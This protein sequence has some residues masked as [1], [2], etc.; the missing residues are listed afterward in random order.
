MAPNSSPATLTR[1][2]IELILSK[3]VVHYQDIMEY[4]G[5][6]R[7]TITKYLN[8]VEAI[9]NQQGVEL[10]RKR[11]QGIHFRGNTNAL[12]AKFPALKDGSQSEE[13][14]RISIM[15][16]LTQQSSPILLDDIADHFF[17]S[18]STLE[19][20]LNILKSS[21]GLKLTATTEG[22]Q[23]KSSEGDVR[24]LIGQLLQS[25]WGQ[26]IKQNQRTGKMVRT[27]KIPASLKRYVDKQTLDQMQRVLNQFVATLK[28]DVNEYQYESLLIHTTIAIQR[29]RNGEYISHLSSSRL[30]GIT[31]SP[32]TTKLAKMLVAAFGCTLPDEEIAYLNIHVAAIEDG[33]IDLAHNGIVEQKMVNWLRTVLSDYDNQLLRN[34]TLHL[35]PAL[36]RIKNGISI[37]NPYCNQVK[38]YFPVAFD[39]A[40]ALAM[41]I[42]K[43]YRL[44]L[45]EDEIAYLALHFESFIER[46]KTSRS[47]VELVIVCSTGYG[48]AELLKQRV[49]DK[50]PNVNIVNTLSV[51]EL[52]AGPVTADIV[53]STIP[54]RLNG[55]RVIQVTPFLNDHEIDVL[56]KL[57]QDVRKEKYAREAFVKL[58]SPNGIITNSSATNKQA[59]II[60]IT[61]QLQTHG[62][63]D[64]QMQASAL[65]R[66]QVASTIID[67]FAIPHGDINHVLKPTIGI[68][69]S[70]RGIEWD[71][72]R[73]HIVFFVAL[74]RTVESQMDDIYSYF[75]SLIQNANRM[76]ALTK[77]QDVQSIIEILAHDKGE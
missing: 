15:T 7:K 17:I 20:D 11:G 70:K 26:E 23:F 73:V 48:T 57:S 4:T 25:Y 72:E 60:Q 6:S 49:M 42:T 31:I 46:R 68:L 77:A 3:Q 37:T 51:S 12:L 38:T 53:I 35:R 19:R 56:K 67:K 69:T 10:V 5:M 76:A 52:M 14:R 58:L 59:A 16:F 47:D 34:L 45:T 30:N 32:S 9:V 1:M 29:I 18:R 13:E 2:I 62:Y 50:L 24:R 27:F 75:Y 41:A 28:V 66:E 22:I 64:K 55:T 65:A 8:K 44:Q 36:V 21:Y 43:R 74:N 33:Y 39:H 54:L 40:L 71:H 61:D 63:V